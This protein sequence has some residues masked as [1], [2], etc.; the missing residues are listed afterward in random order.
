MDKQQNLEELYSELEIAEVKLSYACYLAGGCY[1]SQLLGTRAR[2]LVVRAFSSELAA[3]SGFGMRQKT[4][5]DRWSQ[6]IH[7][8]AATPT[9]LGFFKVDGGLR[10]LAETLN[11]DHT[12]LFRNL[13]TWVE[14][15][16]PLVR[17]DLGSRSDRQPLRWIQIPL[18]TDWLIWTAE[19]R[20]RLENGQPSHL[21][22]TTIVDLTEY[23]IPMGITP[24][25]DITSEEASGLMGVIEASKESVSR[26]PETL[27]ARI[28]RLREERREKFRKIRR[29]GYEQREARR[30]LAPVA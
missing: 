15:P 24:P 20:A 17:T 18:L 10:G 28:R 22:E 1:P 2:H 8:T 29:K 6:L 7:L 30:R 21:Y 12:T 27:E 16:Y 14:R 4:M 26:G 25:Y 9:A 5:R 23:M 3:R 11:T 19:Q 13:K